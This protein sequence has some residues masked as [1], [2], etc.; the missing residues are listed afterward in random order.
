MSS[1]RVAGQLPSPPG[2]CLPLGDFGGG[3]S[4]EKESGFWRTAQSVRVYLCLVSC[5][6]CVCETLPFV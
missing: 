2:F 3:V 1:S 4:L 6:D 5:D